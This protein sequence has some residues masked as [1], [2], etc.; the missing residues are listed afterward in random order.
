MTEARGSWVRAVSSLGWLA[1][2]AREQLGRLLM[3]GAMQMDGLL[4][5][6]GRLPGHAC[7]SREQVAG[8]VGAAC[9]ARSTGAGWDWQANDHG[10]LVFGRRDWVQAGE[11]ARRDGPGLDG[12]TGVAVVGCVLQGLGMASV[13]RL[14]HCRWAR[15]MLQK[16]R[17]MGEAILHETN[18]RE[19][20]KQ[21]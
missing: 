11:Q 4:R 18:K 16:R 3:E 10:L 12:H 9:R 1:E 8:I 20:K 19:R 21:T 7:R 2:I 5:A 15:P 13:G 6:E 17:C 14:V